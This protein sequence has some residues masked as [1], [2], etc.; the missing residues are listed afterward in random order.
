M[1]KVIYNSQFLFSNIFI[2]NIIK[3]IKNVLEK[4]TEL[5]FSRNEKS[6]INYF[7]T[8]LSL[9]L[10]IHLWRTQR[11]IFT[12]YNYSY[13]LAKW[14]GA[15]PNLRISHQWYYSE[16]VFVYIWLISSILILIICFKSIVYLHFILT[17]LG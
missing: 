3:F 8:R 2:L 10:H 12:I 14:R 6:T 13:L 16:N 9:H 4:R 7:T 1:I 5:F 17:V 11:S 15:T